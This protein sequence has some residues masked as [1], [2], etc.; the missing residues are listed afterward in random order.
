MADGRHLSI[1][2]VPDGA[3][4]ESRTFRIPYGRLKALGIVVG[5]AGIVLAVMVGSWWY[6]A[7]RSVRASEL[8]EEVA[9]LQAEQTRVAILAARLAELEERYLNLRSLFGTDSLGASGESLL[10]IPAAGRNA[11]S[12]GRDLDPESQIPTSWPLTERGFVTRVLLADAGGDHPGLDIAIPGG[13]YIRAAGA[14]EVV[15]VGE[16]EVYGRYVVLDHGNGYRTRYA[17]ASV[18]LVEPNRTVRRNEVIALSGST[19]QSTAPHLHFEIMLDGEAVDPL[20]M[21]QRP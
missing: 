14:G 10:P 4:E 2:I 11:V 17:H 9:R 7:A 5:A 20:T 19:G 21:L 8:E 15:D 6:L 12:D 18:T 3:G 1:I 13:S 16:D